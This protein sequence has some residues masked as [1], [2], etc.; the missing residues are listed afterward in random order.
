MQINTAYPE[1]RLRG[2]WDDFQRRF[3]ISADR[4]QPVLDEILKQYG[5]PHRMYH[6]LM[7]PVLLFDELR[8]AL[9]KGLGEFFGDYEENV[10]L[11]LAIWDH[12]LFYDTTRDDNEERSSERAF[13][14]ARDLGLSVRASEQAKKLVLATKHTEVPKEFVAQTIVDLDLSLLAMP[15]LTFARNTQEIRGEYAH[16]SDRDFI[17]GRLNFLEQMLKRPRIYSTDYFFEEFET[18]AQSNME[19]SLRELSKA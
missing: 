5:E 3:A 13:E 8:T 18:D 4:G 9:Q 17:R 12:D 2:H 14:H 10:A 7:H 11:E 6:G 15:W 16:I 1:K 19:R